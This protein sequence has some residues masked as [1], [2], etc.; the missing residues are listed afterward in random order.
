MCGAAACE[1]SF[2]EATFEQL[3]MQDAYA[4]L[5]ERLVANIPNGLRFHVPEVLRIATER[6]WH[7]AD[8]VAT[9]RFLLSVRANGY[10]NDVVG[11]S[12]FEL[13]LVPDFHL[14]DDPAALAGRLTRN[15]ECVK[16][17][18][19]STRTERGRVLEL[20]LKSREF[21]VRLAEFFDETGLED[22]LA[23]TAR[24]V[25]DQ[26]RWA[27]SFDKWEFEDSSGFAQQLSIEV[28][29]V[30]LPVVPEDETDAKLRPLV[31]EKVLLVGKGGTKSF[32]V[33]FRSLPQPDKVAGLDHFRV[34]IVAQESGP[35]GLTRRKKAW[36]GSRL[37]A[38]L[39]FSG[40]AK[41]DWDEGWHFVRVIPCTQ[42]G[43][44]LPM[45]DSRG[46]PV[47]VIA[48]EGDE[49]PPNESDLFYVV[50]GDAFEVDVPQRAIPKFDSMMHALTQ[51]RFKAVMDDR[52]PGEVTCTGVAWQDGDGG[53][54]GA[55]CDHLELKFGSEGLAHVPV[56]RILRAIE[57]R[58]LRS[59]TEANV[60]RLSVSAGRVSEP[61]PDV[62]DWPA[63]LEL[64][65]FLAARAA[66]FARIR[67]EREALLCQA[68]D[69]AQFRDEVAAYAEAYLE[70]LSHCLRRAETA[71]DH[72]QRA[73]IA[74]LHTLLALDVVRVDVLDHRRTR[75]TALLI[76][77]T[78]PLR[79][80]WLAAWGCLA[81][82][83]EQRA[84]ESRPEFRVPARE[85]VLSRLSMVD[86]PTV[87][88]MSAGRMFTAVDC[89]HPFWTAYAAPT[90]SDPR[91][92]VGELC[93]ALGLPEPNLGSFNLDGRY[94]AD[95]VRRYLAQHPYV[96][97]LV[98][99]CFNAGRGRVLADLL[100]ELQRQADHRDLRYNLRL[101]VPD[102]DASG[103]GDDLQELISPAS[104]LTA[105]EADAFA[106]PTGDHLAPKL[107]Y[108]VRST[109][110]FRKTP[111]SYPA[112]L[113]MLFDAFPAQAVGAGPP[114]DE[115]E[116]APVHG[117]L[118]DF[119]VA[120]GEEQDIVSWRRWPRH[121]QAR[122][123]P[124]AE[125]LTALLAK[126]AETYSNAAA[127][128]ATGQTGAARRPVCRLVLTPEDRALLHQVH[129]ASDWV[130]TVDRA[131]G[132]EFFDHGGESGRPEYL[133]DHSPDLTSNSGRR[134]VITSRS[135]TE[136]RALF[137]RV[138]D[139]YGLSG[140]RDRAPAILSQLRGLSSRLA[141]KLISAPTH[142]AEALGLALGKMY[143]EYLEV[144]RGQIVVPLDAHLDLYRAL[145]QNAD[146]LGDEISLKR[147]DLALFDLDASRMTITANLVEVKCYHQA[148]D[149]AGFNQLKTDIAE[150]IQQS[151][152]VLQHHFDPELAGLH[153][154]PDRSIKT[155]ELATLLEFY[156]DRAA[157]LN[158]L[159]PEAWA[160][161]K[162]FLRAMDRGYQLRFTRSALVFDF[163]KQGG[164]QSLEDNGIEFHRIG[165]DRIRSLL[166][167]LPRRCEDDTK[168]ALEPRTPDSTSS[169][170]L[171][172]VG[173][174]KASVA[175]PERAAF[176]PASRT[177]STSWHLLKSSTDEA[178]D[179]PP[180]N[181]PSDSPPAGPL[182]PNEGLRA[183]APPSA[184]SPRPSESIAIG[185]EA[186]PAQALLVGEAPTQ[187][188]IRPPSPSPAGPQPYDAIVGVTGESP[189]F[190][191]LGRYHGRTIALDLNQTHTISLF[192]VQGGGKSYTLGSIIEMACLP[193]PGINQLPRPLA[194][195][196]FHYSETQDYKPEFTSMVSPNTDPDAI[197]VLSEQYHCEPKSLSDVV[198]LTPVDKLEQRQAE[199]PK[200]PVLPLKFAS[201]ELQAGHW[202]FLMGAVGNQATYIRKLN[203]IMRELRADLTIDRLRAAID[204]GGLPNNVLELA[205]LRLDLAATYIDDSAKLAEVIRPGRLVIVDL[206]D[207][208]I[209]KDQALGL[210]V[211]LLQLFG[212]ATWEGQHFNKLVVF[213]EAHKYIESPDLVAGLVGIV[214][215]MRHKGTSVLV[216]SQ[217][218]PSVPVALIELSSQIVLHRFNSP[219]WLKHIQKANASLASLSPEQLARLPSGEAFLWSAKASEAAFTREAVRIQCRPRAT[220]HGGGTRTAV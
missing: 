108:S 34:Q 116:A 158:Y 166:E 5:R 22:P 188:Q 24:I 201:S 165:V 26:N 149:L 29:D 89:V 153:D 16:T 172:A 10:D 37:D 214:R 182:P 147:T 199:Y 14:L 119:S 77:P 139:D 112:H 83:W 203:Q 123:I 135:V 58:T 81:R 175:K 215:E 164:E 100:M 66:L 192:G 208:F 17:L 49:R 2:A 93:N 11:A 80:A 3:S 70:L 163:A 198:L 132:I 143:L 187:L 128:V 195:V 105:S 157:R 52:D 44:P 6:N 196:V 94:L 174:L 98:V 68:V 9:V 205:H 178:E 184:A 179:R 13:G 220:L 86:F 144:F 219:A 28:I 150:Q 84:R 1:D 97:T 176:L 106:A 76:G 62:G 45:V 88:P 136:V 180:S 167:A 63:Q 35:L 160:E 140:F 189:Q 55:G 85:A 159:L 146:E 169:V 155:H 50:K 129:D 118:Q 170:K 171:D 69:M 122:A 91:G 78:H 156:L 213:D 12:L 181:P 103:V 190:G 117:L 33:K 111:A 216:A 191:I 173:S 51:V 210:F 162:Y 110:D 193:L 32:K 61:V 154:R 125:D 204:Q 115:D 8:P 212:D 20:G 48:S 4:E 148:G 113:S 114:R 142:R 56:S 217:D 194:A 127:V 137:E 130:F 107:T 73:V 109:A 177:R 65:G 40:L 47:P 57:Q 27:Y 124:G 18:T 151:A 161:A 59:P 71:D 141:L 67:G 72:R 92:L 133:I 87:L 211:V 138:L 183:A 36:S 82:D 25:L 197:R 54:R 75:R 19:Y 31:Q 207:E 79:C 209:E 15:I 121:G 126:L 185:A 96:H 41:V 104:S 206:R 101:F 134:L 43:D 7:W 186:E 102:G 64:D 95:R 21:R 30:A 218:P 38:S 46:R 131:L 120:Y 23:W 90:E 53:R 202:R 200:I 168:P 42:D 145:R 152:A 39:S 99:N 74:D 60:W